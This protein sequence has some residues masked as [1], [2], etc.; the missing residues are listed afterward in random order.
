MKQNDLEKFIN[1]QRDEFDDAYP[2]LKL[3]SNIEKELDTSG[4]SVKL[5]KTHWPWYQIAAAALVLIALG[6]VGGMYVGNY[7]QASSF[8]AMIDEV[9]PEF[10]EM[11]QYYNQ[12]IEQQYAK[13]TTYTTDPELDADL[14]LVDQAME[15]LREELSDAP[16]GRE[17]Q[18]IEALIE[19]YRLKLEILERV[20][21]YIE[22]SND[23]IPNYNSN[24][25][26]I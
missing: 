10:N 19:N 9:A 1:E 16:S 20:L 11:E 7:Q 22:Q 14:A 25:T 17:S 13:L 6:G 12:R 3:W 15:E 21:E 4:G 8:Q 2:S 5:K 18:I 23:I 24:E 26:S